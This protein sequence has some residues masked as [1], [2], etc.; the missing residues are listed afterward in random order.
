MVLSITA[1]NFEVEVLQSKIPVVIDA[2]A[3]WCGPC[4]QMTPILN[5]LEKELAGVYKICKVNVDEERELAVKL[6]VQS[7]PT[8]IFFKE[9]KI[10]GKESGY[11]NKASFKA[12][13]ESIVG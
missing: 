3:V 4:K 8:F 9:G 6:S 7:I 12:K 11:M 10:V 13:I 5:E 2:Y 1:E